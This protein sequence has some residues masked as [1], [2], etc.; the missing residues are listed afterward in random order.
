MRK[1][2]NKKAASAISQY[3]DQLLAERERGGKL[4]ILNS[5]KIVVISV[6]E[7]EHKVLLKEFSIETLI[8]FWIRFIITECQEQSM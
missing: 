3:F 5:Y 6:A 1:V 4:G 7:A 2:E 8:L